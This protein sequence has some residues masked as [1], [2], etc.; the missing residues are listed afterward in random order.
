MLHA[1]CYT[2]RLSYNSSSSNS[3]SGAAAS[4]EATSS[5]DTPALTSTTDTFKSVTPVTTPFGRPG[6]CSLLQLTALTLFPYRSTCLYGDHLQGF[7]PAMSL[8][9]S[10]IV[11][12]CRLIAVTLLSRTAAVLCAMYDCHC[13]VCVPIWPAMRCVF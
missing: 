1:T 3:K 13:G 4:G 12:Y 9:L 7:K 2:V 10:S 6:E 11:E 8:Q 5:G